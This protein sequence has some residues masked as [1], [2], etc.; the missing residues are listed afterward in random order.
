MSY[1]R[2]FMTG[3][4]LTIF[5]VMVAISS[6][7]PPG[8]RFMTFVVGIPAIALCLLQLGLDLR[9]WRSAASG[10]GPGTDKQPNP[11]MQLGMN[12]PGL[13]VEAYTPEVVRR[14]I[15]VWGYILGL[16]GSILLFG[17]YVS[18]PVFLVTFLHFFAEAT[19]RFSIILTAVASTILYILFELVFRMPLHTGF[20]TD[21]I[22]G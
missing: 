1:S 20:L 4:M 2:F 16:I 11:S 5:T 18:I 8:A 12:M 19:W 13:T 3:L 6:S 17:F 21:L 15:I 22:S 7:Y 9:E 10:G 14:E